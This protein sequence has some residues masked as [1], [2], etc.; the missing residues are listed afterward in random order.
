[1]DEAEDDNIRTLTSSAKKR[2]QSPMKG[3][4]E[5]KLIN[6]I[7]DLIN[8]EMEIEK[9]KQTLSLKSD[10]NLFDAFRLFDKYN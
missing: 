1:M 3:K 10:F 7:K 9:N 6:A 5:E 8:I 4:E 2:R